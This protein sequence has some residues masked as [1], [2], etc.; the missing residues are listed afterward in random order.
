MVNKVRTNAI[1]V[2]NP[3]KWYGS[4]VFDDNAVGLVREP[5]VCGMPEI[6]DEVVK[7]IPNA[8]KGFKLFFSSQPFPSYQLKMTHIR[9]DMGGNWYKTEDGREGWLCPALFKYFKEAPKEIFCKAE[10]IKQ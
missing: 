3:Y 6:I 1:M 4:W 2:I 5:F 9:E 10:A 8:E 7:S